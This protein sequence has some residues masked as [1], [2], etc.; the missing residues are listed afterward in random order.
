ML[1]QSFFHSFIDR[2]DV[3]IVGLISPVDSDEKCGR[4]V[5]WQWI[6]IHDVVETF[7][8]V[9]IKSGRPASSTRKP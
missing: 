4:S 8:R 7:S 1:V 5:A 6:L 2:D 9:S 3:A